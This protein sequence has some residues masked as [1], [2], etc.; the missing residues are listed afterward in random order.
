ML[1]KEFNYVFWGIGISIKSCIGATLRGIK[2][3]LNH[4]LFNGLFYAVFMIV[5]EVS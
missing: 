1:G 4:P 5:L 2:F 3:K